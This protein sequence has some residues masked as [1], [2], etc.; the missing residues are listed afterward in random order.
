M[1]ETSTIYIASVVAILGL[2]VFIKSFKNKKAAIISISI[3]FYAT[4]IFSLIWYIAE[5]YS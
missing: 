1:V 2:P 5:K 4:Y 3:L